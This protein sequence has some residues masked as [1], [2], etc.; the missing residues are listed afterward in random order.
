MS[1]PSAA[2]DSSLKLSRIFAALGLDIRLRLFTAISTSRTALH[3]SMLATICDVSPSNASHHLRILENAGLVTSWP[4]GKY[5]LYQV[6]NVKLLEIEL[7]VKEL[8]LKRKE[9]VVV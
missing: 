6:E 2:L 3:T 7:F 8:V 4:A 9:D 5:S 1:N